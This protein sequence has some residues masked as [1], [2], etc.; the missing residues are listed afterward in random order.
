MILF[1]LHLSFPVSIWVLQKPARGT[2]LRYG[3]KLRRR[4]RGEL[5]SQRGDFSSR[6]EVIGQPSCN[7]LVLVPLACEVERKVLRLRFEP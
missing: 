2:G 4:L 5:A 7:L 3:H 1:P 6:N